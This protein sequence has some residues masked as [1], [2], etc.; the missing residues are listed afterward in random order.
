MAE[1]S[2][3][4]EQARTGVNTRQPG[5]A[6]AYY[7]WIGWY[8][9]VTTHRHGEQTASITGRWHFTILCR[10]RARAPAV[11]TVQTLTD[12]GDRMIPTLG[13]LSIAGPPFS[14]P[15]HA[16]QEYPALYVVHVATRAHVRLSTLMNHMERILHME[17]V[18]RDNFPLSIDEPPED[19][20][21]IVD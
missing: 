6:A 11:A 17:H 1:Y 4:L 2:V 19:V 12:L 14:R 21:E 18:H 8:G 16:A 13:E 3:L 9:E 10:D 7:V 5:R 20:W 15:R